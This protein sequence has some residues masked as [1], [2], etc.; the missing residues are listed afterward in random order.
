[1]VFC[2]IAGSPWCSVW[3]QD[4]HGVLHQPSAA[5]AGAGHVVGAHADRVDS[6]PQRLLQHHHGHDGVTGPH[7]RHRQRVR[8]NGSCQPFYAPFFSVRS[9]VR[10]IDRSFVR[11]LARWTCLTSIC[12]ERGTSGDRDPR[13][14]GVCVG[15]GGG[16]GL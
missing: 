9:F 3:L 14:F 5:A 7:Q 8:A 11:S 6:G 2:V 13:R 15:V 12:L 4:L 16:G 10:S 1:M